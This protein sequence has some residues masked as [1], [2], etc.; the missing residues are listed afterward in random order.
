MFLSFLAVHFMQ[1]VNR[2]KTSLC[3]AV[4]RQLCLNIP[5][6][7]ILNGLFG[8]IGIIWTQM[9]ADMINVIISYLIY[10]YVIRRIG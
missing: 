8:M 7:L 6:M 10:A 3:L 4:I 5:I 9:T 1:A 2:G